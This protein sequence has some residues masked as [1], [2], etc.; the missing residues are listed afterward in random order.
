MYCKAVTSG[1]NFELYFYSVPIKVGECRKKK[2]EKRDKEDVKEDFDKR[3]DNLYRARLN[4]RR[5]I[6]CNE[7]RYTKFVTLTYA[8]TVLDV[9]K[10]QR[11]ITTFV[12][13]MRRK[14]YEMK[15][16][17]VLEHQKERGAREGNAGCIHIHMV[18]FL[19]KFVKLE[20]LNSSWR[21]GQTNIQKLDDINN[22]GAYVCK[23]ITKDNIAEFGKRVYSCS[24]GLERSQ[25]ERYYTLG[26][27]DSDVCVS[28][29]DVI[30]KLD[31]RYVSQF[32]HDFF[33]D[34]GTPCKQTVRYI[35]GKRTD[36]LI[37]FMERLDKANEENGT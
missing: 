25:Q 11:D 21:H 7:S 19:D 29:E 12:Q 13:S 5:V 4:V 16:L 1:S 32:T 8:E 15:Y 36:P 20:D 35:Q 31:I 6:W 10:V 37:E 24:I 9:K 34:D 23:Y 2:I 17:Y 3:L 18:L 30:R 33:K 26:Y 22:V 27:S 14:G 28:P